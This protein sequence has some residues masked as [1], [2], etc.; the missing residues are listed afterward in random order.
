[1]D[2]VLVNFLS[3]CSLQKRLRCYT[4]AVQTCMEFCTGHDYVEFISKSPALLTDYCLEFRPQY[5]YPVLDY[6]YLCF[7]CL[8]IIVTRSAGTAQTSIENSA[9]IWQVKLT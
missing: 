4:S 6:V 3:L 7:T 5:S 9:A 2:L 1:M 8:L